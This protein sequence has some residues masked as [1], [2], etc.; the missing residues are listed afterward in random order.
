M[1]RAHVLPTADADGPNGTDL[2]I[3]E[4]FDGRTRTVADLRGQ[5][6]TEGFDLARRGTPNRRVRGTVLAGEPEAT[7][8][9]WRLAA[10][11]AGFA[12]WT[13][14]PLAE[15]AVTREIVESVRHETVRRT[16]KKT[17]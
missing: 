9:A 14:R 1:R 4:A 15:R 17:A 8:I 7:M 3:A 16:L 5:V 13:L 2:E 11:A 12:H 6:V 10:A